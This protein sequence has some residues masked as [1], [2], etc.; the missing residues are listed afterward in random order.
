MEEIQN[1]IQKYRKDN[2]DNGIIIE[3]AIAYFLLIP[4]F[5]KI[6]NN[7]VIHI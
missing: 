3:D 4:L 2:N 7:N 1:N 6:V 5:I